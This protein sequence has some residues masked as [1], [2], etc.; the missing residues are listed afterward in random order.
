[1]K[2]AQNMLGRWMGRAALA[3]AVVGSFLLFSGAS[4][5]AVADRDRDYDRQVQYTEW[6]AHEAAE[7]FGYNSREA[8]HWRHE[9][10]EARER[11]EHFWHE[12]REHHKRYNRDFDHGYRHDRY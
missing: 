8:K 10:H 5:A 12:Y 7:Q 2:N 3:T 1:M 4:N 11:R 9:N 6:R